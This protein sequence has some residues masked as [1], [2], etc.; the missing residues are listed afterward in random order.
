MAALNEWANFYLIVGPS[1]GALIG[2][3]FVVVTLI[4]DAPVAQEDA[5]ASGAFSTPSVVHFGAVLFLSAILVAPGPNILPLSFLWGSLGLLGVVYSLIVIC[6]LRTQTVYKPVVEDWLFHS[7]FPLAA[8]VV[9]TASACLSG[10]HEQPALFLV[11]AGVL[12]LLLV[13]IHNAWD[14]VIYHTFVRKPKMQRKEKL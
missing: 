4:A 5:Q 3:Q 9:L 12:L 2:L 14:A 1:A 6:R 8:Y 11:A 7:L 10:S 13:G